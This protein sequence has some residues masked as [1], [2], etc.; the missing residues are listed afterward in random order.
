MTWKKERNE[1][2]IWD[3]NTVDGGCQKA[4]VRALSYLPRCSFSFSILADNDGAKMQATRDFI[5]KAHFSPT[6]S[7]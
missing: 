4:S 3:L 5:K 7:K 2:N 1:K 6:P